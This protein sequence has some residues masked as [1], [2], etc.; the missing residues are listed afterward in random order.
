MARKPAERVTARTNIRN[1]RVGGIAE[2]ARELDVDYT[3]ASSMIYRYPGNGSPGP[4]P[5]SEF[6]PM[7]M[8]RLYDLDKW[9]KWFADKYVPEV[10]E[11]DA[12]PVA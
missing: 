8:G 5:E 7:S 3:R 12:T 9:S 4:L 2:L 1:K 10:D 6:P 11:A